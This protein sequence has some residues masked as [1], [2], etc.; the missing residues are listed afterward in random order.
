MKKPEDWKPLLTGEFLAKCTVAA[1]TL[2]AFVAPVAIMG[3]DVPPEFVKDHD[4]AAE[5]VLSIYMEDDVPAEFI[6]GVSMII[7]HTARKFIEADAANWPAGQQ[8]DHMRALMNAPDTDPM[9]RLFTMLVMRNPEPWTLWDGEAVLQEQFHGAYE[10]T[11]GYLS[12][13][14]PHELRRDQEMVLTAFAAH[15]A[16]LAYQAVGLDN[17][18]AE[19]MGMAAEAALLREGTGPR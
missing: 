15:T 10:L 5:T 11:D 3:Y 7:A 6:A 13:A 12:G 14:E 9:L 8:N 16:A 2:L 1:S 19:W 18:H 17:L 4:M